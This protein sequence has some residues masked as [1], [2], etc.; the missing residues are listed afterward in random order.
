MRFFQK[1]LL[2]QNVALILHQKKKSVKFNIK[3]RWFNIKWRLISRATFQKEL[4]NIGRRS[5]FCMKRKPRK[6]FF[7][8]LKKSSLT[9]LVLYCNN[10]KRTREEIISHCYISPLVK[11]GNLCKFSSCFSTIKSLSGVH[12][13]QLS[14]DQNTTVALASTQ[15]RGFKNNC[16]K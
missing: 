2:I 13:F 6:L 8:Q 3:W 5:L 12:N 11:F 14:T 1:S 16:A 15:V 4:S 7:D 9:V 10:R